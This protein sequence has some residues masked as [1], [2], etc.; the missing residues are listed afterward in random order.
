MR[1]EANFRLSE[2]QPLRCFGSSPASLSALFHQERARPERTH[3]E[4]FPGAGNTSGVSDPGVP[5]SRLFQDD[6]R[7]DGHRRPVFVAGLL[8]LGPPPDDSAFHVDVRPPKLADGTDAVTRLVR[9][10]ERDAKP[11]VDL[12]GHLEKRQVFLLHED[13]PFRVLLL[14]R[15][16]ALQRV[17]VKQEAAMLVPRLR[18]PVEDRQ[19]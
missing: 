19:Q 1:S 10:H 5:L 11:P 12:A 4:G 16:Q 6:D 14:G 13:D 15:L 18:G 9:E 3:V 2:C 17:R 8:V 7:L